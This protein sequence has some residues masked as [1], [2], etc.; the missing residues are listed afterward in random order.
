MNQ[1]PAQKIAS[2]VM[3]YVSDAVGD[4][5]N[6]MLS[7]GSGFLDDNWDKKI[8]TARRN[9]VRDLLGWLSDELYSDA[10]TLSDL[11]GDKIYELTGGDN[12]LRD[13]VLDVLSL[14]AHSGLKKAITELRRD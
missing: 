2:E 8:K 14:H 10:D 3:S 13:L 11:M 9:G 7:Q 12:K 6:D 1:T 4:M 5:A